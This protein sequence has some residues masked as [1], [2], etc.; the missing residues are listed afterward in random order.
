MHSGSCIREGAVRIMQSSCGTSC[1]MA[2]HACRHGPMT[3]KELMREL[4][5]DITPED[6]QKEYQTY[7]TEWWGSEVRGAMVCSWHLRCCAFIL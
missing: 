3:Y 1:N 5:D 4:P 7:L 6:A 2:Y